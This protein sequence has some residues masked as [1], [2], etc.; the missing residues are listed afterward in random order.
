MQFENEKET[1]AFQYEANFMA[2]FK[3][4]FLQ[5]IFL[6]L[7]LGIYYPWAIQKI[8]GRFIGNTYIVKSILPEPIAEPTPEPV[9]ELPTQE[10]WEWEDCF[11]LEKSLESS[12]IRLLLHPLEWEKYRGK[13]VHNKWSISA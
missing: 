10:V 2:D 7:S 8:G 12:F 13:E 1:H 9:I 11:F 3:F 4:L 6:I 5:I